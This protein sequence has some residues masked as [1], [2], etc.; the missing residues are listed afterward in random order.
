[1]SS[2]FPVWADLD[3]M[4]LLYL[5]YSCLCVLILLFFRSG[6]LQVKL[7]HLNI[8]YLR[9]SIRHHI[10]A[11]VVFRESYIISDVILSPKKC[12]EAVKAE[13]KSSVRRSTKFKCLHQKTELVL[14]LF[15]RHTEHL[16]HSLLNS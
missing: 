14:S 16:E 13:S 5:L 12:A 15:V 3:Y 8:V 7:F 11:C 10:P 1:M 4:D 6:T 2:F 9:R